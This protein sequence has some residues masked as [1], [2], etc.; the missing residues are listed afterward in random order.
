MSNAVFPV[1]PGIQWESDWVPG[2]RTSVKEAASGKEY[3]S[4]LM[5]APKYHFKLKID[6][7]RAGRGEL[8]ALLDFFL[9]RRGSFDSFLYQHDADFQAIDQLM[10]VGNGVT[11]T[12]Q[13]VRGVGGSFVEPVCNINQL[14]AIKV[15][16]VPKVSG[17]DF[18]VSPTGM[19]S[20]SNAPTGNITW[21]GTYY[22]RCRFGKD[23][24]DLRG[25]AAGIYSAGSVEMVG[26]LGALV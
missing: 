12:F 13:I 19:V 6:W 4:S 23:A 5:S 18:T 20:F 10:A 24:L 9:A 8:Q 3:R 2:F 7:V 25:I 22:Y 16:G 11:K 15:S 1:L 26:S 21:S 17:V 14:T